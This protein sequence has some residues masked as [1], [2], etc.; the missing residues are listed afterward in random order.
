[1]S[2]R[3]QTTTPPRHRIRIALAAGLVAAF[4][5]GVAAPVAVPATSG[6]RLVLLSKLRKTD[7]QWHT[8]QKRVRGCPAATT[9]FRQANTLHLRAIRRA[10]AASIKSLR[11]RN[12][13]MSQAVVRLSRGAQICA[14]QARPTG[15]PVQPPATSVPAPIPPR[16]E[17]TVSITVLNVV[18]GATLD[19]S[20][21]LGGLILPGAVPLVDSS[22]LDSGR[23]AL[24]GV[25]CVGLNKAALNDALRQVMTQNLL[26]LLLRNL[27]NLDV[28]GITSQLGALLGAGDY[29]SL[30]TVQRVG[31]RLLRLVPN[32]PVEQL[33][34]LPQIPATP[35]GRAKVIR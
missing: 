12:A 29:A 14:T 24:V 35:I 2:P 34:G 6:P 28:A 31:D 27:G 13:L 3:P 10:S 1:M 11:A 5:L 22:Q 17:F 19:L 15:T 16:R 9:A 8:L 30:I 33:A 18:D 21:M 25:V 20:D 26:I 7:R 23:C 32:G 4:G